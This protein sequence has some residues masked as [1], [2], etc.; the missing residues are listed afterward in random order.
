MRRTM[1]ACA[2]RSP[3]K[4]YALR[5]LESDGTVTGTITIVFSPADTQQG[6]LESLT[7]TPDGERLHF[8]FWNTWLGRI[9]PWTF[10][11]TRS[12]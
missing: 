10:D 7:L 4:T 3:E 5:N 6:A 11:L 2:P 9:G 1:A 8:E 12:M